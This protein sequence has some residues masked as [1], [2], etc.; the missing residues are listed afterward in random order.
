MIR[1]TVTIKILRPMIARE[2]ESIMIVLNVMMDVKIVG[3]LTVLSDEQSL[4]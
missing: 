2:R 1:P 3:L 4:R